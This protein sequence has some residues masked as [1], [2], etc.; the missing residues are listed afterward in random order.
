MVCVISRRLLACVNP[1]GCTKNFIPL[2]E[3]RVNGPIVKK[4][5][6]CSGGLRG[7]ECNQLQN[8]QISG[9]AVR[10]AAVL[11]VYRRSHLGS[12]QA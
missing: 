8:R 1:H 9:R 12:G 10:S 7:S 11:V 4:N 5:Y 6:N 2:N 3:T